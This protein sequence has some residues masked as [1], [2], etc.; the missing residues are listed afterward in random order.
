MGP[1]DQVLLTI[2]VV[3]WYVKHDRG[4][5]TVFGGRTLDRMIV[6]TG[7]EKAVLVR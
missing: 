4:R 1:K 2:C 6:E 7:A 3:F 5:S